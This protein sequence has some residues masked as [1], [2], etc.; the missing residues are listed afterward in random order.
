MRFK[1][2]LAEKKKEDDKKK[3]KPVEESP[4]VL[5]KRMNKKR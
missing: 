1:T 2:F 5:R 3:E 4:E